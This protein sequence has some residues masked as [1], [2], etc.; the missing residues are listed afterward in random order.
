MSGEFAQ[1]FQR[2]LRIYRVRTK[3]ALARALG[4]T[5]QAIWSAEHRQEIPQK[6][7]R[8]AVVDTDVRPEWLVTGEEPIYRPGQPTLRSLP[9]AARELLAVWE[10]LSPSQQGLLRQCA[11]LLPAAEADI[12]HDLNQI[13]QLVGPR[14]GVELPAT[15]I[16]VAEPGRP[17]PAE[18]PPTQPRS[19]DRRKEKT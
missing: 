19:P 5:P 12:R 6:W 14:P 11:R 17:P 8:R 1:I 2:L 9:H 16:T 13:A 7:I 3:S 18:T 15:F 4:I 10:R